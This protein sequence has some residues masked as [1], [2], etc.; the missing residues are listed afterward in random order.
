MKFKKAFSDLLISPK[1]TFLVVFALIL[2]VWGVGTV[3]V[4]Y[5]ILTNDLNTNYQSTIPTQVV[6]HSE[7]FDSLDL[8]EFI[9]RPEVETAEFRDFSLHR[10]EV[11]PDVWIPLWLYGV[12]N[13][14]KFNLA[15][16]FT[17]EGPKTPN[18]GT[19]LI[20]RDGKQVSDIV[21]GSKPRVRIGN[22]TFEIQVSGICFDPAQ[23]PATQDAF[24][25]AYT[26]KKTYS[27]ITG[28]PNNKRLIV[29][30]NNVNSAEDVKNVSDALTKDLNAKGIIISSVDIPKFNQHPHQ[31]QLN[32]LIF[33]IGAIGFL[34]FIMGAV[35]V[36]QLMRS[37]MASQVRQIGILK[38]IGASKYQVFQ[39]YILMLLLMGLMAGI[40]A[41]PLAVAT[42][43]AFSYFVAWKLNF[44][45]LTTTIPISIYLYLIAASL[46]LPVLIVCFNIN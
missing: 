25:Y 14:E 32:T 39:I 26:D 37:I 13:F 36:S 34:A 30:L 2:G 43:N 45:I 1:R 27:Q 4:S 11:R 18:P 24:I 3:L 29:R 44:N 7:K 46:L 23:A 6:F 22:K 35:L 41:V 38:A 16:I 19:I 20:E 17:E 5:F 8:Q 42:A 40:F 9:D 31:W 21:I 10:I 15:R 28:L 33:L 12:E